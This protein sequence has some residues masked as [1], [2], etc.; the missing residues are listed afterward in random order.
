[1]SAAAGLRDWKQTA[2]LAVEKSSPYVKR[3]GKWFIVH[4]LTPFL[5]YCKEVVIAATAAL[6]AGC[7]NLWATVIEPFLSWA[8]EGALRLLRWAAEEAAA[9]LRWVWNRLTPWH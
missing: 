8:V 7:Q 4:V 9:G 2:G 6:V 1:M 3:G 5:F